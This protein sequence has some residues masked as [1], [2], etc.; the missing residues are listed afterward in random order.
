MGIGAPASVSTSGYGVIT[1]INVKLTHD[2]QPSIQSVYPVPRDDPRGPIRRTLSEYTLP[3]GPRRRET[4]VGFVG[5]LV[6]R[7]A[8]LDAGSGI[9]PRHGAGVADTYVAVYSMDDIFRGERGDLR[10]DLR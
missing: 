9:R 10:V 4:K 1:T 2:L 3:S 8:D 5:R 7:E 6:I